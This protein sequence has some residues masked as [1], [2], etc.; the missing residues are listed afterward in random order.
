MSQH[1]D[2]RPTLLRGLRS[3]IDAQRREG[4]QHTELEQSTMMN[5]GLLWVEFLPG[6]PPMD[7][8]YSSA[9][10]TLVCKVLS[11]RVGLL[12]ERKERRKNEKNQRLICEM[13]PTIGILNSHPSNNTTQHTPIKSLGTCI[14]NLPWAIWTRSTNWASFFVRHWRQGSHCD[15]KSV[16]DHGLLR[17]GHGICQ[18]PFATQDLFALTTCQARCPCI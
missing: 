9:E 14:W 17:S 16:A 6:W 8:M 4:S 12:P 10:P 2:G 18:P 7:C 3:K 15:S 1:S 13:A 11:P 5:G